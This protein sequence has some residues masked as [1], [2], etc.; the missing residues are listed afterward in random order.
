MPLSAIEYSLF[1]SPQSQGSGPVPGTAS[2]SEDAKTFIFLPAVKSGLE[3]YGPSMADVVD[4]TGAQF[5]AQA[6]S[7]K[8]GPSEDHDAPSIR[9][10]NPPDGATGISTNAPISISLSEPISAPLSGDFL[11]LSRDGQPVTAQLSVVDNVA[12]LLPAAPLSANAN[13][14]LEVIGAADFA[15]NVAPAASIRFATSGGAAT[16]QVKLLS[17]TPANQEQG[18]DVNTSI[19]FTFDAPINPVIEAANINVSSTVF[20][21]YPATATVSGSTVTI[22]PS[23]ALL[24]DS[25]VSVSLSVADTSGRQTRRPS[26]I[27]YHP[28]RRGSGYV[29]GQRRIAARWRAHQDGGSRDYVHAY[30]ARES[31]EFRGR[32]NHGVLQWLGR[33]RENRPQ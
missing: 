16:G 24:R 7:L 33:R 26:A 25:L 11:R 14:L 27:P 10:A 32:G 19:I 31:G 30:E 18:V 9:A 15:G 22:R 3:L 8:Q 5:L 17:S 1:G 20:G 13:Y 23:H 29:P 4:V 12:K 2:I 21:T 6:I 28:N